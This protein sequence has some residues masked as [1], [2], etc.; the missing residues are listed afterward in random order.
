MAEE[1]DGIVIVRMYEGFG[2]RVIDATLRFMLPP[3]SVQVCNLLED[4][5]ADNSSAVLVGVGF[6]VYQLWDHDEVKA[7]AMVPNCYPHDFCFLL[8]ERCT[9]DANAI[10]DSYA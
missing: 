6:F 8:A 10:P 4:D 9:C 5:L 1:T 2:G 7:S 3:I